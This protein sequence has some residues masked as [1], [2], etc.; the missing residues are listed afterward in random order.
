MKKRLLILTG[1]SLLATSAVAQEMTTK[2]CA[3]VEYMNYRESIQPGYI[4]STIDV[5]NNAKPSKENQNLSKTTYTIPVVV[6]VVY[7]TP[8]QNLPDSVI[9]DQIRVLNE[10]FNRLN[11]DTVNMRSI[12]QPYAGSANIEFKLAQFDPNGNP[13]TGITRTST[14]TTSFGGDF[15]AFASG[16]MSSMENVKSTTNGG[17]DPWNQSRFLNIWICNMPIDFFGIMEMPMVMGYA[18]PPANLPNW[19]AGSTGGLGDGVVI[20]YQV[21]G[22][23]NPNPL[24]IGGGQI[25]TVKGRTV[26]HEVGHYLG[27]RHI[28]GDGDCTQDDGISDTPNAASESEQDCDKT[29]NTCVDNIGGVD[30]PDMVENYMDYSAE[31]CQN[32]FTAEQMALIRA[33]LENERFDLINDNAALTIKKQEQLQASLHPNPANTSITLKSEEYLNGFIQISD[34]NGKIVKEVSANGLETVIDIENLQNGIYQVSVNG[35]SG[36]NKIIKLVKI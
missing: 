24:D 15:T 14:A 25:V 21:F 26:T 3:T 30:L 18:T 27:L 10:D 4:Q 32:T 12:F 2:R 17:V 8:E 11:A 22:S 19:P 5:F 16:D 28:W 35:N 36:L 31:D 33:V 23:N 9:H 34:V 29:K 1:L 6:H 13:T 7:N 20:Q